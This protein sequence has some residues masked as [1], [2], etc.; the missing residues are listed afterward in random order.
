MPFVN[1]IAGGAV[2]AQPTKLPV[3]ETVFARL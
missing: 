1:A 2:L 3:S